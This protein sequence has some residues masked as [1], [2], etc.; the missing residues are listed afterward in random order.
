MRPQAGPTRSIPRTRLPRLGI[1]GLALACLCAF[2][3]A[4]RAGLRLPEHYQ[5]WGVEIFANSSR[6]PDLERSL[7]TSLTRTLAAHGSDR[8]VRPSIADAV[9]RGRILESRRRQ[10]IR[11]RDNRWLESGSQ[12]SV[13]AELLDRASGEVVAR[14]QVFLEVGFIFGVQGGEAG[15]RDYA[16]ENA[17]QRLIIELLQKVD[18]EGPRTRRL[19]GLPEATPDP[20]VLPASTPLAAPKE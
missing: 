15:A 12:L 19:R 1:V 18:A 20:Q 14:S 11:N 17:A 5:T 3:C 2:G 7:H 9:V 4:Y 6:E 16:L 10:G 8:L 13:E